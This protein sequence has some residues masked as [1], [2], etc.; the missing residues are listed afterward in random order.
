M[1]PKAS[2]DMVEKRVILTSGANQTLV[3]RIIH[4]SRLLFLM[5][6]EKT[7]KAVLLDSLYPTSEFCCWEINNV[8]QL[9]VHKQENKSLTTGNGILLDAAACSYCASLIDQ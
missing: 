9:T 7:Q 4:S 3:V 5:L 1:G 2:T 6:D 8:P